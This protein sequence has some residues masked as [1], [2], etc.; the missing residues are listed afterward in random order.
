MYF[1]KHRHGGGKISPAL[2]PPER[3]RPRSQTTWFGS[4]SDL[5]G[6]KI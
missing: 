6:R 1:A 3:K 2:L 5:F 4:L